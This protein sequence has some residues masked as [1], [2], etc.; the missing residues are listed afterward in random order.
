MFAGMTIS[1]KNGM[2]R[3]K[4]M[5][6]YFIADNFG[7]DVKIGFAVDIEIRR[8]QLQTGNPRPLCFLTSKMIPF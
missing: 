6:I 7:G 5:S 4:D 8:I 2:P 1:H 3:R